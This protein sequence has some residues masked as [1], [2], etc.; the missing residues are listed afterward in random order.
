MNGYVY[1]S[2]NGVMVFGANKSDNLG[3]INIVTA[4]EIVV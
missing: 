4:G 3:I 2:E 1:N